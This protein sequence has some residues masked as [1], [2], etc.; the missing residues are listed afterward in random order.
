MSNSDDST[1]RIT[2]TAKSKLSKSAQAA[3]Q[4]V[5]KELSQYASLGKD[6]ASSGT[7]LYPLQGILYAVQHPGLLM[8]VKGVLVKCLT[9][10][11][12]TVVLM[13]ILTYLPQVGMLAFVSGPLAFIAAVPLVLSES[14]AIITFICRAFLLA[15]ALDLIFDEVMIQKGHSELVSNGRQISGGR[16]GKNKV[17]QLGK[18][19]M[20]PLNR[21]SL[22]SIFRYVITLPLN[23]IPGIGTALFLLWN[24][25]RSGPSYHERYFQLKGLKGKDRQDFVAKQNGGY[26]GFGVAALSLSLVPIVSIPLLFTTQIGAALWAANLESKLR[27]GK[28]G[29]VEQETQAEVQTETR[30]EL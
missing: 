2:R 24:G 16:I 26:T 14:A 21:F 15:D 1:S 5:N 4:D 9:A 6:F 18:S 23:A 20:K 29:N 10:S 8:S 13:F 22:T 7:Y 3:A 25:S 11:T 19:I 12:I 28:P 27:D 30:T 17:Q